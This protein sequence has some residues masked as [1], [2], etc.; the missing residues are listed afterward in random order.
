MKTKLIAALPWE[1]TTHSLRL[2]YFQGDRRVMFVATKPYLEDI[3]HFHEVG[4]TLTFMNFEKRGDVEFRVTFTIEE[5]CWVYTQE[6]PALT[7]DGVG[8]MEMVVC[9][10]RYLFDRDPIQLYYNNTNEE[11]CFYYDDSSSRYVLYKH[12]TPK[13]HHHILNEAVLHQ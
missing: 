4:T 7:E 2:L 1:K 9:K 10:K 3:G 5:G 8:D 6:H 11:P 13:E 12:L